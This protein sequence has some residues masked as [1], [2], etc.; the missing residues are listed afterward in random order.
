M[1]QDRL[2][3]LATDS[4][5]GLGWMGAGCRGYY[6]VSDSRIDEHSCLSIE[7]GRFMSEEVD[8]IVVIGVC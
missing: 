2:H 1:A 3:R 5:H 8:L 4:F 7:G 6:Q